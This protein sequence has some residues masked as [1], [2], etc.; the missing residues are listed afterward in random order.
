M[1]II[2][3]SSGYRPHFH[4]ITDEGARA[5]VERTYHR[6]GNMMADRAN[7]ILQKLT[8]LSQQKIPDLSEAANTFKTEIQTLFREAGYLEC[9]SDVAYDT[10]NE[11]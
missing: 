5:L 6:N 9:L 4:E 3:R 10:Y 8:W 11:R 1:L 2:I 7:V